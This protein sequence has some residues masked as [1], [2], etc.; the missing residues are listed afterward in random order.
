MAGGG[1]SESESQTQSKSRQGLQERDAAALSPTTLGTRQYA[2]TYAKNAVE[3]PFG[4]YKGQS[5]GDLLDID[6]ATGLPRS[7]GRFLSTAGNKF[8]SDAS[9]GGS[10]RGQNTPENTN[11]VVGSALTQM[12]I[13]AAPYLQDTWKYQMEMPSKKYAVDLDYLNNVSQQDTA[14]MG[15]E[16]ASSGSSSA[17]GFNA[18][19]EGEDLVKAMSAGSG[20]WIAGV[21]YGEGS[22]E[23]SSIRTWLWAQTTQPW[24]SIQKAY[25]RYGQTIARWLAPRKWAQ[26]IMRIPFN[27][28]LRRANG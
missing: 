10:M 18:K 23:Q 3:S 24:V 26:A 27:Y 20:C 17:W 12:G 15:G 1:Y 8:L 21:L 22:T 13:A 2:N 14:A 5:S 28:M 11:A 7:Y 9:A 25:A 16:S 4:Y 19:L 6:P